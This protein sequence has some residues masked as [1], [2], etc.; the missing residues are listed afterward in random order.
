MDDYKQTYTPTDEEAEA[1][2]RA[3]LEAAW[4]Q[5]QPLKNDDL[6]IPNKVLVCLRAFKA[7][8]AAAHS[9]MKVIKAAHPEA[10]RID[11]YPEPTGMVCGAMMGLDVDDPD[12]I[13][14]RSVLG[15]RLSALCKAARALEALD[16]VASAFDDDDAIFGTRFAA[17][18]TL[19]AEAEI[20]DR[21][22]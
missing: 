6:P 22:T 21:Q 8:D 12:E 2:D 20:S 18:A 19:L 10:S 9:A 15:E 11:Y 14:P 16:T 7:A 17:T 3:G 5:L 13:H 1:I 4:H